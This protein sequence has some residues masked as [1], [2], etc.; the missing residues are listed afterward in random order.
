M[1]THSYQALVIGY[2]CCERR[3]DHLQVKLS[4]THHHSSTPKVTMAIIL[5]F[6]LVL[7]GSQVK[8]LLVLMEEA[9]PMARANHSDATGT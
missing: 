8:D 6:W 3:K 2:V 7:R 5:L 9:V 1:N 4:P